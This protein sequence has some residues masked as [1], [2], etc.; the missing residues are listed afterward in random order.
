[1]DTPENP[2]PGATRRSERNRRM[3]QDWR[4]GATITQL[5]QRYG[6]SLSWTSA[7]L[8]QNGADLPTAGR[9]IK[10]ELDVEQIVTDYLEGATVRTIAETHHVSYG[11]VYNLLRHYDVPMRPRGGDR[12]AE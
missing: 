8:R 10:R 12:S 3:V 9:G 7:L 4:D 6:L 5:A 2:G 1:M 11:K